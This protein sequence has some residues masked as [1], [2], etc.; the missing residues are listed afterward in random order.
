MG[1]GVRKH[2]QKVRFS[3]WDKIP[4]PRWPVDR[5]V[6]TLME[7]AMA[8]VIKAQGQSRIPFMWFWP[9]EAS[10]CGMMTHDVEGHVG[11]DFC[12]EL[13]NIDDSYGIRSAF[14]LIPAGGAE[15]WGRTAARLRR[16]GFE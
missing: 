7:S 6:D 2:L 1:I 12:D 9:D 11:L 16:R 4:F 5:T 3:G 14:Q 15:M 8:L 10:A 13:M